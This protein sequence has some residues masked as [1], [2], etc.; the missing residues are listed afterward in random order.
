MTSKRRSWP[1][2]TADRHFRFAKEPEWQS[3]K[4]RTVC[5]T[6]VP[7]T[8]T[9][10]LRQAAVVDCVPCMMVKEAWLQGDLKPLT[11][12]RCRKLW[13][14]MGATPSP[15]RIHEE[16]EEARWRAEIK[17][18]RDRVPTAL[19]LG[20]RAH[21]AA[22]AAAEAQHVKMGAERK[23]AQQLVDV[24]TRAVERLTK[25]LS[26]LQSNLKRAE[27]R[28]KSAQRKLD[29]APAPRQEMHA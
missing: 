20:E 25:K 8:A 5:G 12:I 21:A 10:E 6:Y 1:Y 2:S 16:A 4:A 24:R 13:Q 22:A 26:R 28:L 7:R 11:V 17:A 27:R 19:E 29:K 23:K 14:T 3:G 18:E 9:I 15:A